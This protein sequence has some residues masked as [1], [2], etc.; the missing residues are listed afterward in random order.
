MIDFGESDPP[1]FFVS[2]FRIFVHIKEKR[3]GESE[4]EK[5]VTVGRRPVALDGEHDSTRATQPSLV[6]IYVVVRVSGGCVLG[7]Y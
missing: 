5:K 4:S 2:K 3:K 6:H 7:L 1:W